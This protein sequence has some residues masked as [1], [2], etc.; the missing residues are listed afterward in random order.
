MFTVDGLAVGDYVLVETKTPD[1]Y[2]TMDDLY[3]TI[4][5]ETVEAADGSASVT[6]LTVTVTDADGNS[7]SGFDANSNTQTITTS[8]KNTKGSVL[9]STGGIGTTIF[10]VV[11]AIMVFGAAVVL[12]TRR[13]M[14]AE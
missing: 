12:I 14:R 1:G 10:Y 4:T 6:K 9:P 2:N 5:A 8:I 13:R 3:L 11:G 7:V